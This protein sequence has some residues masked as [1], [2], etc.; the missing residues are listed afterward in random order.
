LTGRNGYDDVRVLAQ[1]R[2]QLTLNSV[3]AT[4]TPAEFIAGDPTPTPTP[5]TVHDLSSWM[6]FDPPKLEVH[7]NEIKELSLTNTTIDNLSIPDFLGRP[8]EYEIISYIIVK[9]SYEESY[10]DAYNGSSEH[11]F[12]SSSNLISESNE[13]IGSFEN[14]YQLQSGN[15]GT[16][17]ITD[18]EENQSIVKGSAI[19]SVRL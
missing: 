3:S 16:L 4:P 18:F 17:K 7:D 11:V 5:F 8:G 10:E 14:F 15:I 1:D 13:L 6:V 12:G 19:W 9:E 2:I